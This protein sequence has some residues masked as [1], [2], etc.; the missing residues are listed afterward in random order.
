M[1]MG[2]RRA[3][4]LL[5]CLCTLLLSAPITVA[6]A[7][8]T[9]G[10]QMAKEI[11]SRDL[12]KEHEGFMAFGKITDGDTLNPAKIQDHS[13]MTLEYP[14]GIGSLYLIFNLEYGLYSIK[15]NDTGEIRFWGENNFLHEFVDLEAAF[16]TAPKSITIAFD[17]G[18]VNL[19]EIY[20]FTS[21]QVPDFVQRWDLPVEDK[22][23]LILFSTHGDDEQLFF[24]GILPYYAGELGYQVQ[25]VY[26]TNHRNNTTVR[27]H[28]MLNGLWAVG[29]KTYP[30]MG[31]F[32][33]FFVRTLKQAYSTYDYL[34]VSEE[35]MVGFVVEQL[36]RFKPKVVVGHDPINGE[37]K[38][39]M[40][41]LYADLL[42]RA[43]ELSND[44][45][46]YPELAEKYGVWD[47]PKAYLH[48]WPENEI[49]MDWDQP[50]DSF[51]GMTAFEVTKN[52]GYP[53]HQSQY[54]DFA[55][56][57]AGAEKASE[58]QRFGP[59]EYGL[60]R[61]KVGED[62]QKNDF[63]ENVTTYAEQERLETERQAEEEAKRKAEEEALRAEEEARLAEE[64]A[65]RQAVEEE[66]RKQDAEQK[67]QRQKKQKVMIIIAS[68]AAVVALIAI[69]LLVYLLWKRRLQKIS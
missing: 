58:V 57:M 8:E 37:Y 3:V 6:K 69:A 63:F 67:V 14:Q 15:N 40:H 36:R 31:T 1:K 64:E 35:E 20:M 38:H 68:I 32:N 17:S 26:W 52:I 13:W 50:L 41:M 61:T 18:E 54:K 53:C 44:E 48:L 21:G 43:L 59:C 29:V 27:A 10:I 51:G 46:K 5:L 25:V 55:W 45:S 2:L 33:D 56:Y 7:E 62:V 60:Y 12:L 9:A 42:M 30:V 22:T 49:V 16:G 23:D 24:A 47:V 19:N 65:A 4:L 28:E 11:T 66:N 39:G 34:K